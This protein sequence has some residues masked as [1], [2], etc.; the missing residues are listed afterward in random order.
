MA[1]TYNLVQEY[2]TIMTWTLLLACAFLAVTYGLNIYKVIQSTVT[3]EKIHGQ[4]TILGREVDDLDS[5]YLKLSGVLTPDQLAAY[6]LS[7]GKVSQYISKSASLSRL[8][9]GGHEL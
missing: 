8:A 5:Q 6:G 2:R 4:A 9:I 1:K 3:L 7:Q